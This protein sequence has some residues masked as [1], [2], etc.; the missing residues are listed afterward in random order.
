M[1]RNVLLVAILGLVLGGKVSAQPSTTTPAGTTIV[2]TSPERTVIAGQP[3]TYNIV[4]S[5]GQMVTHSYEVTGVDPTKRATLTAAFRRSLSRDGNG[6]DANAG[7]FKRND[8]KEIILLIITAT[9]VMQESIAQTVEVINSGN[10]G[11]INLAPLDVVYFPKYRSAEAIAAAIKGEL[12]FTGF[13]YVDKVLNAL[14]I[15]DDSQEVIDFLVKQIAEVYDVP[16]PKITA[17]VHIV[18]FVDGRDRNV[19]VDWNALTDAFLASSLNFSVGGQRSVLNRSQDASVTATDSSSLGI[20]SS[21][22]KLSPLKVTNFSVA[23]DQISPQALAGFLNYLE[24]NGVCKIVSDANI[25][26]V[27]DAPTIISTEVTMPITATVSNE[28]GGKNR[29]EIPVIEGIRVS[30]SGSLAQIGRRLNVKA[31]STSIVSYSRTGPPLVAT[32]NLDTAVQLSDG[33]TALLSGLSR[34]KELEVIHGPSWDILRLLSKKVTEKREWKVY[35]CITTK[36]PSDAPDEITG[37]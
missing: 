5:S 29:T 28:T 32:S 27:N 18:E 24:A 13:L 19:G 34:Q 7:V 10:L 3:G 26:V 35:I 6:G 16:P 11:F 1:K 9:E 21:R 25:N 2:A 23:V 33:K 15:E 20:G 12:T 36:Q 37:K 4:N 17:K 30:I 22:D 31:S 14:T 8:G